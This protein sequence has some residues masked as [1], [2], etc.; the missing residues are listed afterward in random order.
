VASEVDVFNL[1]LT[2]LN[3]SDV[4]HSK[5]DNS[6]A[7]VK[8]SQFYSQA[9]KKVLESAQ[10]DFGVKMPALALLLD[11]ATLQANQVIYP[12]WR[13][14]YQRPVD[15]LRM[16]AITTQYGTRVNPFPSYWWNIVMGPAASAWG[17]WLP[18]WLEALDQVSSVP[19][20][21]QVILTDQPTAYGVYVTDV[22]NVNVWSH[23]LREAVAWNLAVYI[24][25]PLSASE[26]AKSEAVKMS[27]LSITSALQLGL[28]ERQ[29]DP[30]PD[31]PAITCRN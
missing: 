6:A 27:E 12:G 31:S 7:A 1:A 28:N 13:Y 8:C 10:W 4:V 11:Q 20:Q 2:F 18:P 5:N 30:Y 16:L 19:G 15:C 9:R 25:G 14:V 29:R 21:Q 26:T 24:A 23:K 3:L 22:T 17:P